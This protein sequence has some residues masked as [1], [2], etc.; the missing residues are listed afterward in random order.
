MP[1]ARPAKS[2]TP[3]QARARRPGVAVLPRSEVFAGIDWDFASL[4][5][6]APGSDLWPTTWADDGHLY[7]A[8]G[9]GGGFGGSNRRGRV[10][11][12]IAR[13][14]GPADAWLGTNVFG[15]WQ[16]EA[17]AS[18][19]GKAHGILSV[20]GVL[21]LVVT[22]Q[23]HGWRRARSGRSHDHGRSWRF[24]AGDFE[25]SG[26]DFDE[27]GGAF[28]APALLQFGRDYAGARDAFVY[29]Y[30]E[31]RRN[32]ANTELLLGRV[33]RERIT[34]RAAWRFFAGTA[35]DGSP[36]WTADIREA[37]AVFRDPGG[38]AWGF[39]VS[40]HAP[41]GRYLLTRRRPAAAGGREGAWGV[42]DAPEPWGPWTTLVDYADWDAGTPL[43]G[44][45]RQ[46]LYHFPSAWMEPDGTL[47][48]VASLEDAFHVLRGRLRAREPAAGR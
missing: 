27:P 38:I 40:H 7:A 19:P 30:S 42:F 22:E 5:R 46:I 14:E 18:F 41:S 37:A 45:S 29:A 35:A 8:W 47:W 6:G 21:Y 4:T 39:Q 48:L 12:G 13:I 36:R 33:L 3:R 26:W 24:G 32:D 10:S 9:D 28:A 34:E 31:R 44:A 16:S 25:E 11:L 17:A 43:E 2:A 20:E 23:G 15:G 1:Q